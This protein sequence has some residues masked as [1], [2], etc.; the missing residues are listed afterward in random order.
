MK[1]GAMELFAALILLCT[2]M[3]LAWVARLGT[4]QSGW[5]DA[6]WSAG[7][8]LAA[9]YLALAPF[10][11]IQPRQW[12]CAALA[13]QALIVPSNTTARIQ[14]MHI[15]IGHLICEMVEH[16]LGLD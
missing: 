4:G 12:L 5:V 15:L 11:D 1:T 9:V 14:E 10:H 16:E 6:C 3:T 2:V 8:G 13:D 7:T